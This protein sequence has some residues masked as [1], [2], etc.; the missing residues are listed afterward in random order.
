MNPGSEKNIYT[1]SSMH[2]SKSENVR[3]TAIIVQPLEIQYDKSDRSG[4]SHVYT[5]VVS[6]SAV[7]HGKE[8]SSYINSAIRSSHFEGLSIITAEHHGK[9]VSETD[10]Y[11]SSKAINSRVALGGTR[12]D[13][14]DLSMKGSINTN[15]VIRVTPHEDVASQEMAQNFRSYKMPEYKSVYG[16]AEYNIPDY[17]SVYENENN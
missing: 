6:D 8:E 11:F 17:K 7:D 9:L 13:I 10:A 3:G 12:D 5:E 4:I 16:N 2:D 15:Y 1:V 14:N